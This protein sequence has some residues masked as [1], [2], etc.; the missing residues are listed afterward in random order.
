MKRTLLPLL[1][2]GLLA[3][4]SCGDNKTADSATDSNMANTP[5]AGADTA[6]TS[7]A[8]AGDTSAMPGSGTAMGDANGPT[9]PHKDDNEFMMTAAH[10]DQNE[11]QQSKMA[12]AK[13]VTGMAKEMANK[14]IADHTKSTADLKKIAAKKG[15]TL[16]TDMDAEH[17]AMAP[18]MEKLS[19]KDFEA[20]YLSQ[21]Q[22][23]HQKTANTMMAHEKMT[24]DADLKSFIGK[25]LPV[26]QMHLGMAQ[27]GSDMKM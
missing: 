21:M 15:I 24:N 16:P 10:S 19:G 17:K 26:V 7:A 2:S 3:L 11:I 13:G 12:L 14:M 9:G 27:K 6:A 25:T 22:A 18:E 1:A 20:K 5:A 8:M 23:D 4:T